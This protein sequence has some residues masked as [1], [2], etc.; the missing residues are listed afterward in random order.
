MTRWTAVPASR[1]SAPVLKVRLYL[2]M[3]ALVFSAVCG[4]LAI[5]VVVSRS[6]APQVAQGAALPSAVAEATATASEYLAGR[7][8]T[9][10]LAGGLEDLLKPAGK[11]LAGVSSVDWVGFTPATPVA[12]TNLE[13]HRFLVTVP[14]EDP[15]NPRRYT[16]TVPVQ[17]V[18]TK[19]AKAEDGSTVVVAQQPV[20]AAAP[21]LEAAL[22]PASGLPRFDWENAPTP[23]LSPSPQMD[24]AVKD[25]ATAYLAN[26]SD[27]LSKVVRDPEGR[28]YVGLG[29]F[30][31]EDA[32]VLAAVKGNQGDIVRV[33]LT[34]KGP[35]DFVVPMEF[36][37]LATGV[38]SG[39]PS[40]TAWGAPG[41]GTGLAPY[42]NAPSG[43]AQPAG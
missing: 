6:N 12:G 1:S 14:G 13:L 16:L 43:A 28:Q 25:W 17:L 23:A 10:S 18:A 39:D 3:G 15:D 26:D 7:P 8:V 24:S 21:S 41:T 36:D 9:M 33:S 2:V 42:Q 37:L 27:G 35:G 20:L 31:L 11:P 34:A 32:E 30:T 5:L 38:E 22:R 4:I 19:T 29:G 40:I